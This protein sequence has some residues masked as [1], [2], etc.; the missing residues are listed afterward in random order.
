MIKFKK[1]EEFFQNSARDGGDKYDYLIN[2]YD[3]LIN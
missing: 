1:F 3:L 2:F